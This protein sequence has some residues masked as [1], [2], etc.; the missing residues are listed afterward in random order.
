MNGRRSGKHQIFSQNII[1]FSQSHSSST[2]FKQAMMNYSTS[3]L[4]FLFS[5]YSSHGFVG[6]SAVRS[7]RQLFK[8]N[9]HESKSAL[10]VVEIGYNMIDS[11]SIELSE[12]CS[13]TGTFF[14][15]CSKDPS[16]EAEVLSDVGH[17]FLDAFTF[18]TKEGSVISRLLA[19]AGRLAFIASDYIP[20]HVIRTDELIFQMSMLAVASA[21]LS[22][23]LMPVAH[24]VFSPSSLRE[25]KAYVL[26]F[27]EV[28][29][30]WN[31]YKHIVSN[32][33]TWVDVPP[34]T[35]ISEETLHQDKYLFWVYNG[36]I[37][38]GQNQFSKRSFIS[39]DQVNSSQFITGDEGVSLLKVDVIKL[40][41]LMNEDGV[42]ND[43]VRALLF[44]MLKS[45]W[46]VPKNITIQ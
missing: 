12:E 10:G 26:L 31:K 24:S 36:T 44:K 20:D 41:K 27:K 7:N 45:T 37:N 17:V 30:P 34:N 5:A 2:S 11:S 35:I 18:I 46:S 4:I 3:V 16:L 23:C 8:A 15:R 13:V 43:S 19:V 21:K 25:K 32:A 38:N 39:F 28:G 29:L 42:L 40:Q 1:S 33:F 9:E 22:Q 6:N 14:Q